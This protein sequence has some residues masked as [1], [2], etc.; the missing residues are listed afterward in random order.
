MPVIR[1]NSSQATKNSTISAGRPGL[2]PDIEIRTCQ[3]V[4]LL[5]GAARILDEGAQLLVQRDEIRLEGHGDGARPR[6]LHTAV[7]EDAAG[8]RAHHADAAGEEAGLAQIVGDQQHGRLVR[9]PEVLQDRPQLLAGELVERAERLVQQQHAR[10]MD[11]RAAEIGALEHA[12]GELPGIAAAEALEADLLQQRVGLVAEFGLAQFA[13]LRAERLDD[14]QR[15][16]DV[17]LDRHPRQHGRVLEGHADPQRPRRDLAAADDDD[18]AGRLHQ[19]AD[20]TQ[21]GRF[22]ASGR[23]DQ[24]DEL[25]VGDPQRGL[26]QSRHGAVA[27]AEGH[28]GLGQLDRDRR[29]RLRERAGRQIRALGCMRITAKVHASWMPAAT[30]VEIKDIAERRA[31]RRIRFRQSGRQ[32][33]CNW[34]AELPECCAKDAAF[35]PRLAWICR[36]RR[37]PP[38]RL[39]NRP[40]RSA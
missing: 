27:A 39:P 12:A 16:H 22:A 14:L 38:A 19:A 26:R 25:A 5:G 30:C 7:V 6:E 9:H 24:C 11:Q 36:W 33:A 1:Q 8:P 17:P 10:L 2:L 23:A 28:G 20:E 15:Q 31:E 35:R 34:S 32:T 13:E 18:A 29:R 40:T 37:A 21:N 4:P 3:A